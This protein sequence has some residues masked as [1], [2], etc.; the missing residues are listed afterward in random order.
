[1]SMESPSRHTWTCAICSFSTSTNFNL[2]KH[3]EKF[4]DKSLG[5]PTKRGTIS[6]EKE[7]F[8]LSIATQLC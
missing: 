1:M 5:T 6:A 4:H 8:G 2:V 7:V 3:L